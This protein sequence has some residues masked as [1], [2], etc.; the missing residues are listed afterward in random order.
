MN[1]EHVHAQA[2]APQDGTATAGERNH[3]T[4]C[5][6]N[7]TVT[8]RFLRRK[9]TIGLRWVSRAVVGCKRRVAMDATMRDSAM[10]DVWA[11]GNGAPSGMG[12][13][14]D[15]HRGAALR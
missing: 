4:P 11:S 2:V 15:A 13:D 12:N 10:L 5:N 6:R 9:E 1:M 14:K 8:L 7:V 3:H